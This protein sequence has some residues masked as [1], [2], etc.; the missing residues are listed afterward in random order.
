MKSIKRVYIP[1]EHEAK[2]TEP[3]G[4]LRWDVRKWQ[5]ARFELAPIPE[6][7]EVKMKKLKVF[8]PKNL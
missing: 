1:K 2:L 3:K 6:V 4:V 7:R 5:L 8:P